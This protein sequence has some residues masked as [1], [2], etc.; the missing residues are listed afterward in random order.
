MRTKAARP[1][2]LRRAT[3]SC[4]PAPFARGTPLALVP[5]FT[6]K[7]PRD[8]RRGAPP[9]TR[10]LCTPVDGGEGNDK[11]GSGHGSRAHADSFRVRGTVRGYAVPIPIGPAGGHATRAGWTAGETSPRGRRQRVGA[12]GAHGVLAAA[13][14]PR[15]R[16]RGRRQRVG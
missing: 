9:G 4:M 16:G 1:V 5:H 6:G 3:L 15:A 11:A 14:V 2:T 8:G 13:G 10:I 7:S 12:I